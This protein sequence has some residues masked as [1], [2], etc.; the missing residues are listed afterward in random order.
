LI[1]ELLYLR[2]AQDGATMALAIARMGDEI[3]TLVES[4]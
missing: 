4:G 1:P 3:A 2:Q